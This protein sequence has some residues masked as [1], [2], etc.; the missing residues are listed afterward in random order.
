MK[1]YLTFLFLITAIPAFTQKVYL[2]VQ[3]D[4]QWTFL[5]VTDETTDL[6]RTRLYDHLGDL[7]LP[8]FDRPGTRSG[9]YLI[10]KNGKLGLVTAT[11]EPVLQAAWREIHPIS[12]QYFLVADD[13]GYS[14]LERNEKTLLKADNY[15]AIKL[16]EDGSLSYFLLMQEGKWGVKK[17]GQTA[18]SIPPDYAELEFVPAGTEGCFKGRKN[19]TENNWQLL[20]WEGKP[21]AGLAGT[22]ANIAA[23]GRNHIAVQDTSGKTGWRVRDLT[24]KEVLVLD[25]GSILKPLTDHLFAYRKKG[26][27]GFTVL[28]MQAT[29]TPLV[30]QFRVLEPL[31][32]QQVF[33]QLEDRAGL[34][35]ADGRLQAFPVE[36]I[37]EVRPAGN[38]LLLVKG[39]VDKKWGVYLPAEE[40]LVQDMV[41][42]TILP[43]SGHFAE[44]R[45]A[46]KVGVIN[47]SGSLV[48]PPRYDRI[49]EPAATPDRLYAYWK[50][51]VR[52]YPFDQ[53]GNPAEAAFAEAATK[54]MGPDK[55]YWPD[56]QDREPVAKL[57]SP[58]SSIFPTY[59]EQEIPWKELEATGATDTMWVA[60]GKSYWKPEADLHRL[61][62]WE[63][64]EVVIR[65]KSSSSKKKKK[66]KTAP[67]TKRTELVMKW[68]PKGAPVRYLRK[69]GPVNWTLAYHGT[70]GLVANELTQ[71]GKT[72][73]SIR[74]LS[75]ILNDEQR[76]SDVE[77]IG[78][79]LSDFADG[80]PYAAF[81]DTDGKVG[82]INK[83]GVQA[84][85]AEGHPLR[86]T[87]VSKPAGGFLQVCHPASSFNQTGLDLA[88]F[89]MEFNVE[90]VR[91][92]ADEASEL[93]SGQP[94]LWGY[95][96]PDGQLAVPCEYERTMP[97][98]DGAAVN[99]KAGGWGVINSENKVLVPFEYDAVSRNEQGWIVMKNSQA[100][101]AF[102]YDGQGRR[103]NQAATAALAVS[104]HRLFPAKTAGNDGKYGYTDHQGAMVISPQFDHASAFHEGLATVRTGRKWFFINEQGQEVITLDSSIL[105]IIE[106][107]QF[108]EGLCPIRKTT[109]LDKKPTR[110]YGYLNTDGKLAIPA[111]FDGA[112]PF[113]NGIAIVDS[114]NLE[115]YR[116]G[117]EG[118]IPRDRALIDT[119]GKLLTPYIFRRITPF[120]EAGF[121][122]VTQAGTGK[123]GIIG[124]D[125]QILT[126]QYYQRV[127]SF[128]AGV[129]VS[130]GSS[131]K[132][133]DYT[134][135]ALILPIANIANITHF[136]GK[137][138]IVKDQS[139]AWHHLEITGNEATINEQ[140]LQWMQP[141]EHGY[142]IVR[143]DKRQRLYGRDQSWIDPINGT[144]FKFWSGQLLGV[145]SGTQE[146][147]TNL[148]GQNAFSRNFEQVNKFTDGNAIVRYRGRTGVINA[149]GIFVVPPKFAEITREKAGYFKVISPGP[150]FGLYAPDGQE[151]VPARYHSLQNLPN[152][153]I[154]AGYAD[155]VSYYRANGEALWEPGVQ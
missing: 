135:T 13:Q 55:Y 109:I 82:L 116:P 121:A 37:R 62:Q 53:A 125:G 142:G 38:E 72:P 51:S 39:G 73:F 105:G 108:S 96:S 87:Y 137:D 92:P 112:G 56:Y 138:L 136:A 86:F 31:N 24:G 71:L 29:I 95:V 139:E 145:K 4:Q 118:G 17:Q 83:Q 91:E 113:Q 119:Q 90:L 65:E 146:F 64:V 52:V 75:F 23:A 99:K 155:G 68:V 33:Y 129:T 26:G 67:A 6:D 11:F 149:C 46:G 59:K 44:V 85:D 41:L 8:W 140:G 128:P 120:N 18:W 12:D 3:V 115:D 151:L 133:F 2:P 66:K 144:F 132:L 152:G 153:I 48:V 104:G 93:Q 103:H 76:V 122:E 47:D 35:G 147:Y 154:R 16:P 110:K 61:V 58:G 7:N 79:R 97:F 130:D 54:V 114:L 127:K 10:E 34:I 63:E 74:K 148:A 42:D 84:T 81:C 78:V 107:G 57:A 5:E 89:F 111:V 50:D 123:Q 43:F 126:G 124:K 9:Y 117:Q 32:D 134:G 36:G 70:G 27:S 150:V 131:W 28:V 25:P 102:Y 88:Q 30:E 40:R 69:A 77:M 60:Q 1:R 20:N 21:V 100:E 94:A 101:T 45:M 49:G 19:T 15:Q 106:V 14:I 143:K 141:F 80:L 98:E 22:F